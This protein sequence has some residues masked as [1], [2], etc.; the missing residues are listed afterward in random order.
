MQTGDVSGSARN[1][2]R[3]LRS[4]AGPNPS[5][6][7]RIRGS[8]AASEVYRI[9]RSEIL[10]LARKPGE[11]INDRDLEATLGVS[12]TPIREAVL[13]LAAEG[14]IEVLPNSG[15]FVARIPLA[16]LPEAIVIRRTLEELTVRTAAE[17]ATAAHVAELADNLS[18]QRGCVAAKDAI[19]FH[20]ADEE[21]HA[22]I[23]RAG[24]YPNAWPLVRQIKVQV[25]R[26]CHLTLPLAGRMARLFKEHKAIADAIRDHDPRQ[27]VAALDVHLDGI[28]SVLSEPALNDDYF[29]GAPLEGSRETWR[30]TGK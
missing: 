4:L 19:E 13:R 29:I 18:W 3:R 5:D 7:T 28:L 17:H 25:D 23:A 14:L 16:Q 30:V 22:I 12:R 20:A 21:F 27:A 10:S 1:K 9:L 8:T 24:G 26:Y 2:R 11:P 15:T 6:G